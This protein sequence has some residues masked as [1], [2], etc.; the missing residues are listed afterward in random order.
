MKG[1]GSALLPVT[2]LSSWKLFRAG[3]WAGGD[4]TSL[5][6][7]DMQAGL[8]QGAL[9]GDFRTGSS[10]QLLEG[11]TGFYLL[12]PGPVSRGLTA[13]AQG[14]C[15]VGHGLRR[16]V[17]AVRGSC[18]SSESVKGF[19]REPGLGGGRPTLSHMPERTCQPRVRSWSGC[20][21]ASCVDR[22]C[23]E[24]HVAS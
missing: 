20:E 6:R 2:G 13:F 10:C 21:L 22:E 15:C 16:T 11:L 4:R 19:T 24:R 18:P 14:A 23:L 9:R 17:G 12:R 1:P 8:V 5:C 3:T 7:E